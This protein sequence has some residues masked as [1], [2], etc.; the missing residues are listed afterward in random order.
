M[1]DIENLEYYMII[2][3]KCLTRSDRIRDKYQDCENY[4]FEW[5]SLLILELIANP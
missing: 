1:G 2:I 4:L 5:N 3:Q